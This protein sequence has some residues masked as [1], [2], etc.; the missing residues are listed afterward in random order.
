MRAA[1]SNR[2][3]ASTPRWGKAWALIALLGLFS[4]P[5]YGV[6]EDEV[7]QAGI[8]LYEE[9]ESLYKQ[10]D[11]GGAIE[12]FT[13]FIETYPASI[14]VASAYY[15]LGQS[16][17]KRR[18]FE[19]ARELFEKVTTYKG[20]R[21]AW[22]AHYYL[23]QLA[24]GLNRFGEAAEEF[25]KAFDPTGDYAFA[26][27]VMTLI[28]ETNFEK[29]DHLEST[30]WYLRY[31]QSAR[32]YDEAGEIRARVEKMIGEKLDRAGLQKVL[33]MEP[34]F[35]FDAMASLALGRALLADSEFGEARVALVPLAE[36]EDEFGAQARGLLERV[37][38]AMGKGKWII[39]C[40]L[41]LSGKAGVYGLR[42]RKGIEIAYDTLK[43]DGLDVEI[44]CRDTQ[45]DPDAAGRLY[46]GFASRDRVLVVVG[47]LLS[48]SALTVANLAD[49]QKL[50]VVA[51]AQR[52]GL[53]DVGE[54]VFR[55]GL[56]AS[57]Q[58]ATLVA[59]ATRILGLRRYAILYPLEPYGTEM[60]YL[61]KRE[62]EAQGGDIVS[63]G[64]YDPDSTDFR[65]A[66]E[67]LKSDILPP[68]SVD[69]AV[70]PPPPQERIGLFVPDYYDTVGLL[71]PQLAYHELQ[72]LQLLGTNG[73]NTPQ[74]VKIGGEHVEGAV[75]VDMFF[76]DSEDETVRLLTRLFTE[77]YGG[78]PG[79]I[80]TVSFDTARLLISLVG[81]M[82]NPS[83]NKVRQALLEIKDR[84]GATGPVTFLP[85]GEGQKT[86]HILTV[87]RGRIRRLN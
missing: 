51:L 82:E 6:A 68:E 1:P 57:Q 78:P 26:Q 36:R 27:H 33:E 14:R 84:P 42:A 32:H 12:K 20:V 86:L 45:G 21:V 50:P 81:A 31:L 59:Y 58:V 38:E 53:P 7:A 69:P 15:R 19:K 46:E 64:S 52:E 61:F 18:E 22:Y 67:N 54:Y 13:E 28:G 76:A 5:P 49:R 24:R 47:P 3:R 83:R 63:E 37:K 70:E 2:A 44:D 72:N 66:I 30:L 87:H 17:Y 77:K 10:Q 16:Y 65:G 74:L 39:G 75:F 41:P 29:G 8:R 48:R 40:L 73:W 4:H 9:A 62:V 60:E 80:E 43:S 35:P 55:H 56:T 11:F 23:G 71:A 79:D 34:V 85:N 25:R